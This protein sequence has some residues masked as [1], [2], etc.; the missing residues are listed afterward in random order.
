MHMLA[1]IPSECPR[2]ITSLFGGDAIFEPVIE[3]G[4][5]RGLLMPHNML[6]DP[7]V[8]VRISPSDP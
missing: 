7:P 4:P 2:A 6:N 8:G 5:E 3:L 1:L